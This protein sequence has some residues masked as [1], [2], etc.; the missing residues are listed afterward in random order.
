MPL[1]C[2][3]FAFLGARFLGLKKHSSLLRNAFQLHKR[4]VSILLRKKLKKQTIRF[5]CY[6]QRACRQ[7]DNALECV[8]LLL[9]AKVD[10]A[11][12]RR[13]K[14]AAGLE[15]HKKLQREKELKRKEKKQVALPAKLSKGKK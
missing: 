4:F 2:L 3:F 11:L 9:P 15:Q 7:K 8:T 14:K 13:E 1:P 6:R 10:E 12:S 5:R